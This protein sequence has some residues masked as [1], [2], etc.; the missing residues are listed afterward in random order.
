MGLLDWPDCANAVV[1]LAENDWKPEAR[2][3]FAS[4]EAR[5]RS[6]AK[7]RPLEVIASAVGSDFNDW[8]Q[9]S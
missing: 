1:L 3:A 2:K 4:V 7:G 8:A 9:A 6:L 5:W